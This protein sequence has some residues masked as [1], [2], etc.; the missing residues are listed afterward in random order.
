MTNSIITQICFSH[1]NRNFFRPSATQKTFKETNLF[2]G[3]NCCTLENTRK[4][5]C[6]FFYA[7]YSTQTPH[8]YTP[9]NAKTKN[10]IK[11]K[12]PTTEKINK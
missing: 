10:S 7:V 3:G 1:Y 8:I 11:R 2:A 5:G 9:Y 12:R 4:G 6:M